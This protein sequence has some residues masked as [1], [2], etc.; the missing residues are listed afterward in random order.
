MEAALDLNLM[1]LTATGISSDYL[2]WWLQNLNLGSISNGSNVPQINNGDISSLEIEIPPVAEQKEIVCRL[3]TA[4]DWI[5]RLTKEVVSVQKLV[6]HL[7]QAVLEKAFR[8][9]LVPQDPN[10]EPASILLERLRA[11]NITKPEKKRRASSGKR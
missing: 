9:E 8:G 3:E 5:E 6:K 11:E 2:W 4:F 7:D 1:V 10:D